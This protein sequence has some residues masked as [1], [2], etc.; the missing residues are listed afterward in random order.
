MRMRGGK[1][2]GMVNRPNNPVDKVRELQRALFIAAKRSPKRRFHALFDRIWRG[3]V[4]LDCWARSVTRE[5]HMPHEKTV[6]KPCA[7]NPHARFERGSQVVR[8]PLVRDL[9]FT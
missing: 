6:G 2:E 1:C 9:S 7:G 5:A 8:C 3:D 4:L